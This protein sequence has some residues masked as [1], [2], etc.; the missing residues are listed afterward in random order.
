[1]KPID[2]RDATYATLRE[3]LTGMRD[4]VFQAWIKH[5][6]CT[7]E[8]LAT[9]AGLSILTL[10]PRTTELVQLGFVRL[11]DVQPA[12]KG[13]GVYRMARSEEVLGYLR[14]QRENATSGQLTLL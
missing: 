7:T 4:V 9:R 5:G 6:P 14:E 12:G 11:A 1:M 8:E 10:R 13:S 2:F 3:Q